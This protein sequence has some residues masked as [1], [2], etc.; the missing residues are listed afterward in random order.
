VHRP[1]SNASNVSGSVIGLFDFD[2]AQPGD[3]QNWLRLGFDVDH[4]FNNGMTLGTSIFGA[5]TG[6]DPDISAALT[7]KMP[8]N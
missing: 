2:I 1:N 3:S 7:L 5:T 4:T 8:F 6:A